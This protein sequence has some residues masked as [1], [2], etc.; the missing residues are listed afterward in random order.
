MAQDAWIDEYLRHSAATIQVLASDT[1][2]RGVMVAMAARLTA[3]FRAGN[4]LLIAGNG[5]SAGDAQH[6]AAEFTGRLM[7]DRA[8]LP[9]IALTTDSSALTAIAN[10]YGFR[11]VF[12]RQVRALGR[13]GDVFLGISTSGRS[14]NILAAFE[15]ARDAG[16]VTF[17]FCG[18]DPGPMAAH[19]DLIFAAPSPRTAVVQQVHI[20]AAHAI[21]GIVERELFP[22]LAP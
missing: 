4:K 6:L 16:L 1:Q 13:A 18:E 9:A 11:H 17:G 20:T 8:P 15:A 14:A 21:C 2:L 19:T 5:G 3:A 22:D 7:F 10:D 12:E